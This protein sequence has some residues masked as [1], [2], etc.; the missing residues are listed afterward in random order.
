MDPQR[1]ST[2]QRRQIESVR[3]R[4]R[5]GSRARSAL[6]RAESP[7]SASPVRPRPAFANAFGGAA[8]LPVIYED[9][10]ILVLN[11]P[12][13]LPS[14]GGTRP[15]GQRG[16]PPRGAVPSCGVCSRPRAQAGQGYIGTADCRQKLRRAAPTQRRSGR[17]DGNAAAQGISGPGVWGRWPHAGESE[18]RDRMEKNRQTERMGNRTDG[19]EGGAEHRPG[20]GNT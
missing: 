19:R 11:K 12:S 5:G 15:C 9:E 13:G 16:F 6:R 20:S 4:E 3:P 8:I 2:R 17:T 1:P 18:L 14:Q 7:G 10:D